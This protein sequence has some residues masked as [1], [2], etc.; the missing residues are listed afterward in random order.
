MCLNL[1]WIWSE[2]FEIEKKMESK[3]KKGCAPE[4]DM[5]QIP[6][7]R[8]TFPPHPLCATMR[9]FPQTLGPTCQTDSAC[10]RLWPSRS[11]FRVLTRRPHPSVRT[12]ERASARRSGWLWLPRRSFFFTVTNLAWELAWFVRWLG[13]SQLKSLASRTPFPLRFLLPNFSPRSPCALE[14]SDTALWALLHSRRLPRGVR[15]TVCK[16]QQTA[17][18]ARSPTKSSW[19]LLRRSFLGP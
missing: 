7:S 16:S 11:A 6:G 1:N 5:G 8:P 3:T 2:N 13:I 15:R 17:P 14:N 18:I 12:R 9:R 19:G 4:L 10:S